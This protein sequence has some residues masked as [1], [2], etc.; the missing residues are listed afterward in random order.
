MGH[1]SHKEGHISHKNA[2]EGLFD[3]NKQKG[4]M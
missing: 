1:Y 4:G 3:K 2:L